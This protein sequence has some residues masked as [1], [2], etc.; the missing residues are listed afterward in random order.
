MMEVEW[1]QNISRW[2]CVLLPVVPSCSKF[3]VQPLQLQ[4][5]AKLQCLGSS[6]LYIY[7]LVTAN[8]FVPALA[9]SYQSP[10]PMYQNC[11][12]YI[13]IYII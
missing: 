8:P 12:Y 2:C 1:Y 11:V 9:T 6:P 3:M 7:I 5:L 13:Y 4:F 10:C